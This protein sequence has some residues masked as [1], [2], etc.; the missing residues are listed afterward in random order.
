MSF[1]FPTMVNPSPPWWDGHYGYGVKFR[2]SD[3]MV[4]T[5]RLYGGDGPPIWSG[6]SACYRWNGR[7]GCTSKSIFARP[8][9][10]TQVFIQSV[11]EVLYQRVE[12]LLLNKPLSCKV[13]K[14]ITTLKN[15][16]RRETS[17]GGVTTFV[18]GKGVRVFRR[19]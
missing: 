2:R 1:N 19:R 4:G 14:N 12:E 10:I 16:S 5:V 11:V 15:D 3:Y 13:I 17:S 18:E 9:C 8:A 6:R 7:R